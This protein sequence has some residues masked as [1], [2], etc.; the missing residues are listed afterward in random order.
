MRLD[1]KHLVSDEKL[2]GKETR[3]ILAV[4]PYS[5]ARA[6]FVGVPPAPTECAH[7][8]SALALKTF[9]ETRYPVQAIKEV[10]RFVFFSVL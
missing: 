10:F 9:V 5:H 4:S 2:T 1:L 8:G 6:A 7:V 3:S